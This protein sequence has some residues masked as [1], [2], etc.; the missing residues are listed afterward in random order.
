[1]KGETHFLKTND[2]NRN[3]KVQTIKPKIQPLPSGPYYLIHDMEPKIVDD[4]QNSKG[5]SLS[6]VRGVTLCRCGVSMN[7]PFCDGTQH[8]WIF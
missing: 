2:N 1:M 6:A 7:K 4:I 3:V 8:Y 5:E